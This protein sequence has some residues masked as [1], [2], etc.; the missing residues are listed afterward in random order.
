MNGNQEWWLGEAGGRRGYVPSNYI[1]KSEY[2]WAWQ[3]HDR[4]RDFQ[5]PQT[6]TYKLT[7]RATW[8]KNNAVLL[9]CDRWIDVV[10]EKTLIIAA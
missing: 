5:L 3:L 6:T 9:L 7:W 10:N 2:T 1:R 4:Q 8:K